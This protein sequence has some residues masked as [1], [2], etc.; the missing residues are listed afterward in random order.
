MAVIELLV[1]LPFFISL[2]SDFDLRFISILRFLMVLR[3]F[4][5]DKYSEALDTFKYV[6][7]DKKEELLIIFFSLIVLLIL[8]SCMMY[9]IESEGN[10]GFSSIPV[11]MWWAISTLTTV[12]YGD[13]VPATPLG[14]IFGSIISIIGIAMFAIPAG[15]ISSSFTEFVNL[16]KK[17]KS[18]PHCKNEL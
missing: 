12:G 4:K 16:K 10:P 13:V 8:S 9:A 15:L 6:L 5:L 14:K 17:K 18:C 7:E 2:L 11:T 1:I 3:I